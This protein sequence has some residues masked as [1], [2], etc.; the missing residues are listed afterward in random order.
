MA[1]CKDCVNYNNCT[2]DWHKL[3]KIKIEHICHHFKTNADVVEVVRCKDC[4]KRYKHCFDR[5]LEDD[6][7]CSYEERKTD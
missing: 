5:T 7:Y 4:W 1:T 6:D 3:S 2:S